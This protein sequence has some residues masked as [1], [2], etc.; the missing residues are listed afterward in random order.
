MAWPLTHLA[1]FHSAI[2]ALS[3]DTVRF[4][5][6][7]K[8]NKIL[9]KPWYPSIVYYYFTYDSGGKLKSYFV[10]LLR[11]GNP[12]MQILGTLKIKLQIYGFLNMT[13]KNM[14]SDFIFRV[15]I[16]L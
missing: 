7:V 12:D 11:Y 10:G 2:A 9:Q 4:T 3:Q 8:L 1:F 16:Y 6:V 14:G 13:S 15:A 5:R